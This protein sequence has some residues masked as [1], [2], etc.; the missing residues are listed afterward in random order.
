FTSVRKAEKRSGSIFAHRIIFSDF[1]LSFSGCP[2]SFRT[3]KLFFYRNFLIKV[4]QYER[5][6]HADNQPKQINRK[7]AC[8]R[9][10]TSERNDHNRR[11]DHNTH[12][13]MEGEIVVMIK[14]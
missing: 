6:D 12:D 8:G 13:R 10:E 3:R 2:E 4:I 14:Q 11:R 5:G 1:M 9:N 7:L